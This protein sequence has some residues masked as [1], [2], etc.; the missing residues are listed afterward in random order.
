MTFK[1]LIYSKQ[2]DS[3]NVEALSNN[4]EGIKS[5]SI[6]KSQMPS[7]LKMN[8]EQYQMIVKMRSKV[9]EVKLNQQNKS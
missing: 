2:I 6:T 3:K 8:S 7:D 5:T 4:L 1:K 9:T